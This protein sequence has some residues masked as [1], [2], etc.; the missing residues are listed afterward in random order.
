[1]VVESGRM[2]SMFYGSSA[3]TLDSKGRLFL[4]SKI[5]EQLGNRIY[6]TKGYEGC[7]SVYT[8]DAFTKRM[9]ELGNLS[10]NQSAAR[11]V[12]RMELESVVVLDVDEQGRVTIPSKTIERYKL[13]K[14]VVVNGVYNHFEIWSASAWD[15]YLKAHEN[16]FEEDAEKLVS[17]KKL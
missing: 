10:F 1:M 3:Y 11:N 2:W 8:E 7:L 6:I 17:E 9:E 14:K 15:E 5:R 4:S 13:E 12:I 16:D